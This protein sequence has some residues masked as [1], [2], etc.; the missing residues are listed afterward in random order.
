MDG[1][2]MVGQPQVSTGIS[3]GAGLPLIAAPSSNVLSAGRAPVTIDYNNPFAEQL[4]AG[5]VTLSGGVSR[6]DNGEIVIHAQSAA[7]YPHLPSPDIDYNFYIGI[8]DNNGTISI[9]VTGGHDGFPGY[10]ILARR[11]GSKTAQL[12]YGYTPYDKK[13][14]RLFFLAPLSLFGDGDTHV[15][16]KTRLRPIDCIRGSIEE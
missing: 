2:P 9:S 4:S 5:S 13:N 6:G 3:I 8:T 14:H 11:E 10:E 12:L 15:N 1:N 7:S 16:L